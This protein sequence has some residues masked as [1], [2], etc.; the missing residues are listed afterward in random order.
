MNQPNYTYAITKFL[1]GNLILINE[2][3]FSDEKVKNHI[4]N[5]TIEISNN[6]NLDLHNSTVLFQNDSNLW[7]IFNHRAGKFIE[8]NAETW[9]DAAKRIDECCTTEQMNSTRKKQLL[10]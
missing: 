9:K 3:I 10:D 8:I 2:N 5:I 4:E 1:G 7:N 6:R